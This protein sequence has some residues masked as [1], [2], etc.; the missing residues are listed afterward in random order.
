MKDYILTLA[1]GWFCQSAVTFCPC[2]NT[3]TAP[4][5]SCLP[6]CF[7]HWCIH[8]QPLITVQKGAR[9]GNFYHWHKKT[10]NRTINT[11][12][13]TAIHRCRNASKEF[14]LLFFLI[15]VHFHVQIHRECRISIACCQAEKSSKQL[16]GAVAHWIEMIWSALL[17][18][19]RSLCSRAPMRSFTGKLAYSITHG[20][21]DLVYEMDSWIP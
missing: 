21:E 3:P 1:L 6:L 18:L 19:H 2:C 14:F 13:Q 12:I 16:A 17:A 10:V 9:I 4:R 8:F 20:K 7:I 15:H 5:L 11:K